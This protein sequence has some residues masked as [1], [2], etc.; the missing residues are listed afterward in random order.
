[1]TKEALSVLGEATLARLKE[2]EASL[3]KALGD[4]LVSLVV[5]GSTARGGYRE[6]RSDVDVVIVVRDASREP[7]LA[8]AN[9][10]QLAR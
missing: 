4:D 10:L 9:A 8:I 1:M 2:L 6:G 7:L 5:Y 3:V